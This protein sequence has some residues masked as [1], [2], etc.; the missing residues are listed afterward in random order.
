MARWEEDEGYCWCKTARF[1]RLAGIKELVVVI[2]PPD[3]SDE[4]WGFQALDE[5]D[6]EAMESGERLHEDYGFTTEKA[7]IDYVENDYVGNLL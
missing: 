7:V 5:G 3:L 1:G 6:Y 4:G 2:C